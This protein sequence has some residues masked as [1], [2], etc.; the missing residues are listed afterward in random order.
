MMDRHYTSPEM[1]NREWKVSIPS[2]KSASLIRGRRLSGQTKQVKAMM[3]RLK[4]KP[5]LRWW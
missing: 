5:K 4:L 1:V 3:A 2:D